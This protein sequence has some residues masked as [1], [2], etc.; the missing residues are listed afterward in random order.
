MKRSFFT[1]KR[2]T[3]IAIFAALMCVCAWITI[4]NPISG[5]PFTL[6]TFAIILAGLLL[7]PMEAL[8]ASLVYLLLGAVG[9]PVFSGFNTLYSNL[10]SPTGGYIIGFLLTPFIISICVTTLKKFAKNTSRLFFVF[11]FI[12]LIAGII[13]VDI[14]G[15]IGL[16]I[17]TG[18]DYPSAF[19]SGALLFMPTDALK[20][21][22]AAVIA[23]ALKKPLE[24]L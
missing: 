23:I 13:V 1:T 2:I 24:R 18:M 21:A 19:V 9:L 8:S 12:A 22:F 7:S 10:F 15:V 4:P 3:K 5:I 11:L 6:Q 16:H 20:C 17:I 14:P